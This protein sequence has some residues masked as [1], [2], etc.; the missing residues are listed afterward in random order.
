MNLNHVFILGNLTR[1]PELKAISSG[2]SVCN[3]SV[4]T[5][6]VWTDKASGQQQK[7]VD[8]H[9]I[10]VFGR[11]AENVAQYMRKGSQILVEGRIQTR[12][13]NAQD[14]SKRYRTDIVADS[15]Q[16]GAKPRPAA[17]PAP[18]PPRPAA[19]T[20]FRQPLAAP[21]EASSVGAP[22]YESESFP[23]DTSEQ[24]NVADIPF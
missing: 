20:P 6:R 14:G 18:Q 1:D 10:V 19:Q 24:I 5:N 13:W 9:N 7:A 22:G 15:I 16:F 21:T 2:T 11:M 3:F 4:A 8:F 23:E 17:P 12:S